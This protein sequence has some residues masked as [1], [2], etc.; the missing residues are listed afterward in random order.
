[1]KHITKLNLAIHNKMYARF[2]RAA[3]DNISERLF[4]SIYERIGER[5]YVRLTV[6][7]AGFSQEVVKL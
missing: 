3:D 2:N 4:G 1:M 7:R 5:L 6:R